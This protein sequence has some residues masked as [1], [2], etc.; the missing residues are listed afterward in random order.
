MAMQDLEDKKEIAKEIGEVLDR[1]QEIEFAY[2]FG[3]FLKSEMFNDVDV[4]LH[5]FKNFSPYG[6]MKFSLKVERALEKAMKPGYRCKFD[7]KILNH[8]PMAFQYEIIKTGKVVFARD[9]A[10]RIRY[11]AQ[12]LSSYLDYKE[13]SDWLDREFLAKV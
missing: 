13:T 3:S 9:E 11:E 4:A 12:V 6:R 7:V 10:K 2:F 1:F 5:V 8:A